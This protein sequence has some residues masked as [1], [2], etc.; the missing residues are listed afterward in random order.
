MLNIS[1][2]KQP[3]DSGP[4][5][6]HPPKKHTENQESAELIPYQEPEV[7]PSKTGPK[8]KKRLVAMEVYGYEVGRGMRKRVVNPEDVYKLAAIGCTDAEIAVW[9]DIDYNTL[10]YNFSDILAKGRQD[11]KTALRTAMIKNA[12]GGN[13]ALQI[14]LSKNLLGYSDNPLNTQDNQPLPWQDDED[15][16]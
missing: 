12:M 15:A 1:M 5:T 3:I 4:V 9:F 16:D 8:N 2:E 14:F 10:R 6:L 13:A 7:D 11:L